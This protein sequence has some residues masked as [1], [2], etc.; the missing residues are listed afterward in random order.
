MW[1]N[2]N[3]SVLESVGMNVG[4]PPVLVHVKTESMI[5]L[6]LMEKHIFTGDGQEFN[7]SPMI[8]NVQRD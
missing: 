8:R 2:A 5:L 7:L 3:A 1:G 4:G 6:I